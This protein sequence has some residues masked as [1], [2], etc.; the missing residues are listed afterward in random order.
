MKSS[1]PF[2][3][4]E[5]GLRADELAAA[6]R[7]LQ[8]LGIEPEDPKVPKRMR[9]PRGD[10]PEQRWNVVK[11]PDELA[12]QVEAIA[13]S[14]D[15]SRTGLARLIMAAGTEAVVRQL[16]TGEGLMLPLSLTV[17][18]DKPGFYHRDLRSVT[19]LRFEALRSRY[20]W[21]LPKWK[22]LHPGDKTGTPMPPPET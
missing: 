7:E 9:A 20:P 11:M 15:V 22:R 13:E 6:A 5:R 19:P 21:P 3:A 18:R 17:T 4:F 1:S 8:R 2:A 12:A 10:T 14:I 16:E